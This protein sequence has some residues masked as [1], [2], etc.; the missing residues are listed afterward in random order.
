MGVKVKDTVKSTRFLET[1][2]CSTAGVVSLEVVT[3]AASG[4]VTEV[5][6]PPWLWVVWEEGDAMMI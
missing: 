4:P 1:V 3:P 2:R 6:L 5:S